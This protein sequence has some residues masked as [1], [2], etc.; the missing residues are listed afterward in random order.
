MKG[1]YLLSYLGLVML[2]IGACDSKTP[3][4][5]GDATSHLT[6]EQIL[7]VLKSLPQEAQWPLGDYYDTHGNANKEL[8]TLMIRRF[9]VTQDL[10]R[11]LDS[12]SVK[13]HPAYVA[14][15]YGVL[16]TVKDPASILWLER[17][18][19]GPRKREICDHWLS[20]WH[21]YL[22]GAGPSQTRWLTGVDQWAKFF[23][24][25]AS[26]EAN[27]ADRLSVLRAMQGWLHDPATQE[28]FV[29]LQ[30]S[31]KSTDEEL[32]LA[33]L[34]LRQHGKPFDEA[35]LRNTITKLRISSTGARILLRY[36][37]AIRHEAFLPSL[38]EIADDKMEEEFMTPERAIEAITFQRKIVGNSSWK[39][40][41]G[42]NGQKGRA[43][44]MAEAASQIASIAATDMPM[45]KAILSKAKH[46]WNDPAML[47]H[48]ERLASFKELHSEIAGWINLTYAEAPFLRNRLL[49]LALKI[50]DESGKS[51]EPWARNLMQQWDLFEQNKEK[52]D[53][54]VRLNNMCM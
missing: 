10:C 54:Y 14:S 11:E 38:I 44:W 20:G 22:R 29:S 9:E 42:T 37:A 8:Q 34:Y 17:S 23:R 24:A 41:Y 51:L 50:R 13:S 19:K 12:L 31:G 21:E 30:S 2:C 18:L 43:L 6:T 47:P 52:W 45:A 1:Q 35:R 32:L 4:E 28:F 5:G 40:W 33:Q 15:L 48:M 27:E 26:S 7:N 16:S 46:N 36:A 25:W 49:P 53:D 39:D 3:A